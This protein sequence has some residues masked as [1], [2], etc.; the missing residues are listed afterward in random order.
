MAIAD[1]KE[2][3]NRNAAKAIMKAFSG[4]TLS[5]ATI[6]SSAVPRAKKNGATTVSFNLRGGNE[7]VRAISQPTTNASIR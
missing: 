3:R 4:L 1:A 5:Q 6:G 2:P 7:Y